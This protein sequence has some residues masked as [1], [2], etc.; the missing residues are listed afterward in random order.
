MQAAVCRRI[1]V[2]NP[3]GD[4]S[5]GYH[6]SPHSF[7][8]NLHL[9]LALCK[10][11]KFTKCHKCHSSLLHRR[12][13]AQHLVKTRACGG[14]TR[15]MSS[16]PALN[17]TLLVTWL[18]L[19]VSSSPMLAHPLY[20]RA[21]QSSVQRW[22]VMFSCRAPSQAR[23]QQW[24]VYGIDVVLKQRSTLLDGAALC[25]LLV[26]RLMRFR[27]ACRVRYPQHHAKCVASRR[28]FLVSKN[29]ADGQRLREQQ[30]FSIL[31]DEWF[32]SQEMADPSLSSCERDA[33]VPGVVV[34]KA[35]CAVNAA[36]GGHHGQS[37]L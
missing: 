16:S 33:A 3:F 26:L 22:E 23:V 34:L 12:P 11:A 17:P 14:S 24:H 6:G 10:T 7:V 36:R 29:L 5:P 2:F 37:L 35:H 21:S 20:C 13:V 8:A 19:K 18:A 9:A 28:H 30:R 27:G 25:E 1:A 15:A 32:D 31:E 4:E